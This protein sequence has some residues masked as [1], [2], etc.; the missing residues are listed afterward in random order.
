MNKKQ[1]TNTLLKLVGLAFFSFNVNSIYSQSGSSKMESK[2]AQNRTAPVVF[3]LTPTSVVFPACSTYLIPFECKN[4]N[5]SPGFW[6]YRWTIGNGWTL[7][8][9]EYITTTN[10]LNLQPSSPS[11]TPSAVTVT[12]ILN[13]TSQTTLVSYVYRAPYTSD[14]TINGSPNLCPGSSQTF[15]INGLKNGE[16]VNWSVS[17]PTIATLNNSTNTQTTVSISNPGNV[18]L[19]ATITNSCNQT[20]TKTIALHYGVPQFNASAPL[21]N[22]S[23]FNSLEPNISTSSGDGGC[24]TINLKPVFS[25]TNISEYQWEKITQD[26]SWSTSNFSNNITLY[27]TCN[28]DFTFKV[29]A[30][31]NCGWSPWEEITY[32]MNRCTEECNT[33]NPIITGE[34]FIISPNPVS[35]G[36]LLGINVNH[37]APWFTTTVVIDPILN[38][39]ISDNNGN[40]TITNYT[41]T[42]NISILNQ[43]GN[44]VLNFPNTVLPTSLDV[45]SLPTG[46]YLVVIEYQGQIESN[47]IIKE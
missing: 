15:N 32:Y 42:V 37:N 5:N 35:Q 21:T 24:N 28:K 45:S 43:F 23:G 1:L 40:Q 18:T 11:I 38:Q 46:T 27:P 44:L 17:N 7:S 30:K 36:E 47:T 34:N 25:T 39:G 10:I 2:E 6:Y 14:A 20:V 26:V 3:S 33:N 16:T 4:L 41:P 13:A 22:Q 9:G 29:R 19:I 8:P 31:N 12:P